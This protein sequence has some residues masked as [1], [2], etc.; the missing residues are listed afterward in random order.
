M[1]KKHKLKHQDKHE[2]QPLTNVIDTVYRNVVNNSGSKTIALAAW[3]QHWE[4]V[5]IDLIEQTDKSITIKISEA[6]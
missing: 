6:A 1:N 2:T 4:M 5:R 3:L